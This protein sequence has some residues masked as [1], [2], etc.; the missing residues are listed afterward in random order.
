[1]KYGVQNL[2]QTLLGGAPDLVVSGPNV[3]GNIGVQLPFSGT[4]GAASAAADQ[5]SVPGIAFSGSTGSQT[6]F[7]AA[8]PD[9]SLLYAD[10]ATNVTSTILASGAPYLPNGTWVNVNFP[11]AGS[12]T[13][14]TSTSDFKFVLARLFTATIISGTDVTTCGNDGRLPAESAVIGTDGCYASIA[15]GK[16]SNKLDADEADQAMVL[17]KLTKILSCLPS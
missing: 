8:T 15:V 2:S 17:S 13:A 11:A 7:D 16:A 6:G 3:G 10:L 4:V 1:M 12:G 14:C 9:Y 5:L